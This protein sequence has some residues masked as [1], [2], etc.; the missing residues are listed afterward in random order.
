MIKKKQVELMSL[1]QEKDDLEAQIIKLHSE[2]NEYDIKG[3]PN[4]Y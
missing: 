3:I 4:I 2:I 1:V